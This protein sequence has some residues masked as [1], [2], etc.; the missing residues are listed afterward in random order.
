M[1]LHRYDCVNVV[2]L[3]SGS[4]L[5]LFHRKFQRQF[6]LPHRFRQCLNRRHPRESR[7]RQRSRCAATAPAARSRSRLHQRIRI[8]RRE[9][10]R[11]Q[12]RDAHARR[13]HVADGLERV[14]LLARRRRPRELPAGLEHLV[15]KAMADV[16]QQQV[17][18][19]E[20]VGLDRL[21]PRPADAST[22]TIDA[23]RLVVERRRRRRPGA[24]TA[25]RGWRRRSGRPS[26]SRRGCRRVLLDVERHLRRAT[27]RSAATRSGSRYGAMVWMTPR[28]SGPRADCGRACATALTRSASSST[29]RACSDDRLA[30]GVT[31]TSP[32]SRSKMLHA[33]LVLEFF[34]DA[35]RL[36]WVTKQRSAARPKWRSSATRHDVASSV[37]VIAV[38][39]VRQL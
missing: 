32:L 13:H 18:A 2:P 8:L 33:E 20:L 30:A 39:V 5:P 24:R 26:A 22:G 6:N 28:R 12:H 4:C 11:G 21:A 9:R 16:E 29:R 17:L 10:R 1:L 37:R 23:E 3:Y 38:R 14:A 34:T 31:S 36:G 25:A 27:A 15:A 7:P 35:D 19:G